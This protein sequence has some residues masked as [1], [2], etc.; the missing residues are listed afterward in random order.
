MKPLAPLLVIACLLAAVPT[1]RAAESLDACGGRYVD[2]LPAVI[3]TPGVWCLRKDLSTAMS[4]GNAITI[5][6]NNVTFD[7]NGY[8]VGGLAAGDGSTTYGVS[9]ASRQNV[10]LRNCTFRGFFTGA[11]MSGSGHLVEDNRFD[12]MLSAGLIITG[13][14]HMVRRNQVID[15]GGWSEGGNSV[16]IVAGADVLDN[17]VS[18]V[19]TSAGSAIGIRQVGDLARIRGNTIRGLQPGG[20]NGAYGIQVAGEEVAIEDNLVALRLDTVGVGVQG[21]IGSMCSGNKVANFSIGYSN[22]ID[23]GGNLG[24]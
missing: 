9:V 6:T 24:H 23:G 5:N 17:I 19:F 16:G 22:C 3:S 4:S 20:A 1:A 21:H 11:S 14:G 12:D 2:S 13:D 7:C 10:T 18:N 8:R 15:T